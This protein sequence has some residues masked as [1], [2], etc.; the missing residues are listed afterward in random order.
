MRSGIYSG[1]KTAVNKLH[2]IKKYE[3]QA[4]APTDAQSLEQ[5]EG[6]ELLVPYNAQACGE[7]RN[8]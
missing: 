2:L 1:I 3:K 7:K 5:I 6:I 4:L 8:C